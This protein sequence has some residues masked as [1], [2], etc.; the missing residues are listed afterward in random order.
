MSKGTAAQGKHSGKKTHITCRRCGGHTYHA[1]HKKCAK[2]GYGA[3][4][5]MRSYSWQK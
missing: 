3:S 5:K 4:A 2:C 1:S